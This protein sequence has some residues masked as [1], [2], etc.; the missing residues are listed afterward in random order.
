MV[1]L[2]R[3]KINTRRENLSP[4]Y[5]AALLILIIGALC[6]LYYQRFANDAEPYRMEYDGVVVEKP[7]FFRDSEQGAGVQRLLTLEDDNGIR[8]NVIATKDTYEQAQ[9]GMR[10]RRTKDGTTISYDK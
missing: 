9:I 7:V 1:L 5:I 2:D 3:F 6:F 10:V 4:L 8:F